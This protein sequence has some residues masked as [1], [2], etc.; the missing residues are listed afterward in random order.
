MRVVEPAS[1]HGHT[2]MPRTGQSPLCRARRV[3]SI[4]LNSRNHAEKVDIPSPVASL[5]LG[6]GAEALAGPIGARCDGIG[7]PVS[8]IRFSSFG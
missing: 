6:G 4:G 5:P 1:L 7:A 3:S 8:Q 2:D